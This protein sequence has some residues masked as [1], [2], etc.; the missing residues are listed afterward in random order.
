MF[1]FSMPPRNLRNH[2]RDP[3]A[4]RFGAQAV[5]CFQEARVAETLAVGI[6]R[7]G[8]AIGIEI[9]PVPRRQMNRPL[10]ICIVRQA[11]RKP[12][13]AEDVA[14]PSGGQVQRPGWPAET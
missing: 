6:H 3:S 4:E 8:K 5:E 2:C 7:I 9:Q 11:D 10:V 1:F 13:A 12:R 14:G